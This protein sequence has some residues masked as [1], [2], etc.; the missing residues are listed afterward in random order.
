MF[1]V[2]CYLVYGPIRLQV[3]C[4]LRLAVARPRVVQ[5][6]VLKKLIFSESPCLPLRQPPP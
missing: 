5:T 1:V 3:E 2:F 4:G 6:A